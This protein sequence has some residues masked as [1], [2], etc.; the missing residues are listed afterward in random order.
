VRWKTDNIVGFALIHV[1]AA[2][3]LLP[4]F[5]SWAGVALCCAGVFVFGILGINLCFHRLL[6]HRSFECPRW[7][8]HALALFGTCSMQDSPPHWVAAHRKHHQFADDDSDPHSP[9]AGFFWAHMGWLLVKVDDMSRRPLID[10]YARDLI[11]DPFFAWLE[12]RNNWMRVAFGLWIAY[13]LIG[14]GVMAFSGRSWLDATQFGLSLFVWG[15]ALRTAIV[16]HY[17]WSINSITHIWGYRTYETA[18]ASRNNALIALITAGEGWH[19]NHHADS[20]SARHGHEW[21][22][23]DVTW[24]VIR[25]LSAFGLAWNIATPSPGLKEKFNKQVAAPL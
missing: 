17:T 2:L 14:F 10:H 15:G 20:H 16:W 18:D 9:I 13:F 5:F 22:E 21:W 6:T 24:M 1:V 4:W 3:A 7:L 11:R 25:A 19:N 23:L 12:R 8:E